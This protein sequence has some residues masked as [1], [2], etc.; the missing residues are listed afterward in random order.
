MPLSIFTFEKNN[1][2]V[3]QNGVNNS[4]VTQANGYILTLLH[5]LVWLYYS[6]FSFG[7]RF[8]TIS[9]DKNGA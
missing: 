8:K 3:T 9:H 5:N 7:L 2:K 4:K 1:G 6:N